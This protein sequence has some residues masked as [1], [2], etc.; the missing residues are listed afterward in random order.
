MGLQGTVFSQVGEHAGSRP[1]R[2]MLSSPAAG[3]VIV[4]DWVCC[5]RHFVF[6]QLSIGCPLNFFFFFNLCFSS[7]AH[8]HWRWGGVRTALCRPALR[9][10]AE[11]RWGCTLLGMCR[12]LCRVP[13]TCKPAVSGIKFVSL[14]YHWKCVIQKSKEICS[15]RKTSVRASC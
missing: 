6:F 12:G 15:C 13:V 8:K 11:L 7:N 4:I 1:K 10:W 2:F 14:C 5:S 9:G 3:V